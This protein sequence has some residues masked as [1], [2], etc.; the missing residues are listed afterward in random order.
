VDA[1]ATAGEPAADAARGDGNGPPGD[2]R[3]PPGYR[4]E[5]VFLLV[6][7]L[8]LFMLLAPTAPWARAVALTIEAGALVV[9][10][11]TS[12]ERPEVRRRRAAVAAGAAVVGVAFAVIGALPGWVALALGGALA[13]AI[14]PALGGGLLR[15]VREQGVT[16]QVV[17]GSLAIYLL[18]GLLFAWLIGLVARLDGGAYFTQGPNVTDAERIYFSFTVLTTTGFGDFTA[19]Q[20]VGRALTVLE[21]LTGQLYLVTV[22][23]V[24]VGNFR[25]PRRRASSDP[26]DDRR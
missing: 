17:A 24:V 10:I 4:Y 16:L 7:A 6:L 2:G 22:I 21:M 26:D 12:R 13:F 11:A 1:T 3:R 8:L 5:A 18:I 20:A 23:G 25:G 15:M 19:G 9:A 14:P